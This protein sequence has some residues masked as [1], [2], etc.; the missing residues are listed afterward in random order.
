MRGH[1]AMWKRRCTELAFVLVAP[2]KCTSVLALNVPSSRT[3]WQWPTQHFASVDVKSGRRMASWRN[4]RIG[5][6]TTSQ[7]SPLRRSPRFESK[8]KKSRYNLGI[9][10]RSLFCW[11]TFQRLVVSRVQEVFDA[12]TPVNVA[13]VAIIKQLELQ[14]FTS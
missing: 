9:W 13:P 14:I 4:I 5:G 7:W 11:L 3:I 2:Q 6:A 10:P 12:L 1:H 8:G